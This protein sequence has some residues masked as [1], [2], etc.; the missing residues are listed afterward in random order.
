MWWH[1]PALLMGRFLD[2]AFLL[3]YVILLINTLRTIYF[4]FLIFERSLKSKYLRHLYYSTQRLPTILSL[5]FMLINVIL[6]TGM[7]ETHI[8]GNYLMIL[9]WDTL[10]K[11]YLIITRVCLHC[12]QYLWLINLYACLTSMLPN[13]LP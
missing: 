2:V 4:V 5:W 8:D 10:I 1:L 9:I 6:L 13:I 7:P 3:L 11:S 12:T